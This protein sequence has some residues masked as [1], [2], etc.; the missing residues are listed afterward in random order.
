[1]FSFSLLQLLLHPILDIV[2]DAELESDG[3]GHGLMLHR[4]RWIQLARVRDL[5]VIRCSVFLLGLNIVGNCCVSKC[6]AQ[7]D[8]NGG[9][10]TGY[11]VGEDLISNY[12]IR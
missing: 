6:V 12:H 2:V 3:F 1:M 10:M 8:S 11:G 5:S 9:G 7:S 4:D